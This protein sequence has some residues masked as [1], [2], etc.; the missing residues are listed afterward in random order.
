[1]HYMDRK[2]KQLNSLTAIMIYFILC[3]Q[4]AFI[5]LFV[6]GVLLH[7][8]SYLHISTASEQLLNFSCIAPFNQINNKWEVVTVT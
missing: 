8:P 3:T 2:N 6:C 4:R 5:N 1:M 7:N